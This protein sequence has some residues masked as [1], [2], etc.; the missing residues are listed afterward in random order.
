MYG[1]VNQALEA[2]VRARGGAE[3]W[4]RVRRIAGVDVDVFLGNEGYPDEM[5]YRL[6]GAAAEVLGLPAAEVLRLFGHHWVLDTAVAHYGALLRA[7]GRTLREFLIGLPNF[8]TRV[9]LLYPHLQPP[10]FEIEDLGEG[11]IRLRYRSHRAGL[12]PFVVGLL[13]GLAIFYDT[14]IDL[15]QEAAKADGEDHDV[16]VLRLWPKEGR[17][18]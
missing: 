7:G 17:P 1:L 10:R 5:T 12:A 16:F 11:A 2:M 8:H 3:T 9:S 4:E 14:R 6:V 15:A 18:S 13:E